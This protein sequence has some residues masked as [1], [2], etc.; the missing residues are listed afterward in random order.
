MKNH[1]LPSFETHAL[2]QETMPPTNRREFRSRPDQHSHELFLYLGVLPRPHDPRSVK[3]IV[4]KIFLINEIKA[5][6]MI[7]IIRHR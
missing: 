6:S 1:A 4:I 5:G 3:K 2:R 7:A